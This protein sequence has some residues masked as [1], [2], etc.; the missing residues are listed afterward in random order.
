MKAV[1]SDSDM[2]VSPLNLN[3]ILSSPQRSHFQSRRP[4]IVAEVRD[5]G[6]ME[7]FGVPSWSSALPDWQIA[8]F[9]WPT[10]KTSYLV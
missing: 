3:L 10:Q 4:V 5:K 9:I 2:H 8:S 6:M 7:R 1:I